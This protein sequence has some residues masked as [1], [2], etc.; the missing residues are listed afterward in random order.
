MSSQNGS[1]SQV[2]TQLT[3]PTVPMDLLLVWALEHKSSL[4]GQGTFQ[5]Y[6]DPNP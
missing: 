1:N 2:Y 6:Q 3:Q 5:W 4:I